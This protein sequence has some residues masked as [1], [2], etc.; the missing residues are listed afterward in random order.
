[1]EILALDN[2]EEPAVQRRDEH[3]RLASRSHAAGQLVRVML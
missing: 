2:A 3:V 1:M